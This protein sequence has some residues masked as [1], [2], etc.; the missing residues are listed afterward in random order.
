[1]IAVSILLAIWTAIL[2]YTTAKH[3]KMRKAE[4]AQASGV[5]DHKIIADYA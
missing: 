2:S 5:A 4:L 1:M 3:E